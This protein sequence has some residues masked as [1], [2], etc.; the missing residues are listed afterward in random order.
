M[1]ASLLRGRQEIDAEE[2]LADLRRVEFF[3]ELTLDQLKRNHQNWRD[4]PAFPTVTV[5]FPTAM[6]R[7]LL[8][9][10]RPSPAAQLRQ[11]ITAA[12]RT[13]AP[14]AAGIGTPCNWLVISS[15]AS[16]G[17]VGIMGLL[18]LAESDQRRVMTALRVAHGG[19]VRALLDLVVRYP[20]AGC[21]ALTL[22][23]AE[24]MSSGEFW[25]PVAAAL[26]LDL[27]PPR[28]PQL[29]EAFRVAS[30]SVGLLAPDARAGNLIWPFVFQ[31]GVVPHFMDPLAR[32]IKRYLAGN[33]PPDFEVYE[34]RRA[35]ADAIREGIPAG[36]V[37]LRDMLA[38]FAGPCVC[39]AILRAHREDWLRAIAP[40]SVRA[41]ARG[42]QRHGPRPTSARQRLEFQRA[43][44]EVVLRLPRLPRRLVLPTS[45]WS[46]GDEKTQPVDESAS[47]SV[48]SLTAQRLRVGV[49][50]RPPFGVWTREL[51]LWPD[52]ADRP[53]VFRL[54]DGKQTDPRPEADGAIRLPVGAYA[55]VVAGDVPSNVQDGWT[56]LETGCRWI[57]YEAFPGQIPLEIGSGPAAWRIVPRV[58]TA[59]TVLT[60]RGNHRLATAD[61]EWIYLR[62][63]T[64]GQ[65]FRAAG[66]GVAGGGVRAGLRRRGRTGGPENDVRRRGFYAGGQ[67][68]RGARRVDA[69]DSGRTAGRHPRPCAL[70]CSPPAALR[71]AS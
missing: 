9:A 69:A 35:F 53:Q 41:D 39:T 24:G 21:Y 26:G 42:V 44:G 37:R 19:S 20:G 18:P 55:V 30:I 13:A 12:T 7:T 6:G 36:Y 65:P 22:A 59:V 23:A 43:E 5:R 38:S 48:G 2:W 10:Q 63:R 40:A 50:L 70:N 25:P 3:R 62:W 71:S 51:T 4:D 16:S 34:E 57:E 29:S 60:G 56:A 54:P 17:G 1:P 14:G 32:T 64:L 15:L 67:R 8:P 28:H 68:L 33:P 45:C 31:A 47:L 61:G 46:V 11:V 27:P 58:E 52:P 66:A 49:R